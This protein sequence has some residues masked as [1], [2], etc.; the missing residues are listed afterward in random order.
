MTLA[1]ADVITALFEIGAAF[2]CWL[3]VRSLL[4]DKIVRGTSYGAPAFFALLGTWQTYIF[5]ATIGPLSGFFAAVVA[6]ANYTWI[7]L[8]VRYHLKALEDTA[9]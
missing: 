7:V 1:S 3:N 2:F 6:L 4:R 8:A 5:F 9:V